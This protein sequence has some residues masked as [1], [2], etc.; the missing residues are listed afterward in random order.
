MDGFTNDSFKV[1]WGDLRR[2][3]ENIRLKLKKRL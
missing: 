1:G 3:S 2:I